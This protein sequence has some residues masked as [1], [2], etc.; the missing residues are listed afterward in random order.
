M[1][2]PLI[3]LAIVI[4]LAVAYIISQANKKTRDQGNR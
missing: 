2:V 1:L 4:I 3:A